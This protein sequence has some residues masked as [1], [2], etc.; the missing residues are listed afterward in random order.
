MN[1]PTQAI[2]ESDVM[3]YLTARAQAVLLK[4]PQV[5]EY[6]FSVSKGSKPSEFDSHFCHIYMHGA[7]ACGTGSTLDA[8][9]EDAAADIETPEKLLAEKR[10]QIEDL[11]G[12]IRSLED[13]K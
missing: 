2:T 11:L 5:T 8:A 3:A 9:I 4:Y 7:R 12:Q 1:N 13:A 10:Q 6:S